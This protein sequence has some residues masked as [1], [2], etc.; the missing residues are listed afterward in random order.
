M[1]HGFTVIADD[2]IDLRKIAESGQ[3]FRWTEMMGGFHIPH[4]EKDVL[5]KQIDPYRIWLSCTE[6][7]YAGIWKSYFDLDESYDAICAGIT[8]EKDPFLY[9]AI[10]DQHGIRILKQDFWEM[11]ITSIIT[12]NRNIPAIKK[13]VMLLSEKAGSKRESVCGGFFYSFPTPSQLAHMSDEDLSDCKLGYRTKYVRAAA[14]AVDSGN[15]DME[16]IRGMSDDECERLLISLP[17]VGVKV[18]SCAMLFGLHRLN[19]F[20]ID[21]WVK[22]ILQDEYPNGY[23]RNEYSPYNGLFQQYMFEYYRKQ[24]S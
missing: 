8:R 3:C 15:I 12:Q 17:G 16:A 24:H 14:C 1:N 21:V 22:Q 20:P 11:L 18:T 9:E 19:A 10:R 13:S 23:P 5:V 6:E 7:E 2:V 4:R